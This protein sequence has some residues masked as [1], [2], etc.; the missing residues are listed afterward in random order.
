MLDLRNIRAGSPARRTPPPAGP[1]SVHAEGPGGT[2]VPQSVLDAMA[3]YLQAA[4]YHCF[5]VDLRGHGQ[6][7]KPEDAYGFEEVSLDLKNLL[8]EVGNDGTAA[9]AD[10]GPKD[11]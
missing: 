2:Q 9:Q 6:S 7:D 1:R 10:V 3:A 8:Q 5:A 11:L 4:G